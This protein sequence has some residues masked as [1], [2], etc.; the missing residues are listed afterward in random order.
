MNL[1]TF[2]IEP[3]FLNYD[4]QYIPLEKWPSLPARIEETLPEI[5]RFLDQQHIQGTFYI[6]GWIAEQFPETVRAIAQ[7]GHEIGYHSYYHISP[8]NQSQKAFEEDLVKGLNLLASITGTAA[9]HYRAPRFSLGFHTGWTIP[10]LLKHGITISSS[11]MGGRR[12]GERQIPQSPFIFDYQGHQLLE[13]PLNR[14][15]TMD[16]HWVYTGSGYLRLMPLALLQRLYTKNTYNMA[17]FH[18][19]DFDTNAPRTPLLPWYRNLMSNIGNSTTIPKLTQL[20]QHH[21]FQTIGQAASELSIHN[22]PTL[23]IT[24]D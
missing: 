10:I 6:M 8:E 16:I 17:Y 22:L 9:T 3:W 14:Q 5:L 20:I 2:D 15:N 13:F 4:P 1:L 12:Q 24:K 18:P 7:A 21:H 23:K 19:R 11:V